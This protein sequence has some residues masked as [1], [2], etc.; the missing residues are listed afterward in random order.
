MI[1]VGMKG[2]EASYGIQKE[3]EFFEENRR[4]IFFMDSDF[5]IKGHNE[6]GKIFVDWRK[7]RLDDRAA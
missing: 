7:E 1:I 3:I 2:W 4:A 6:I 5:N